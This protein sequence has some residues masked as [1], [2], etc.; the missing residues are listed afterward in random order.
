MKIRCQNQSK[1][2]TPISKKNRKL[3]VSFFSIFDNSYQN[4]I[5]LTKFVLVLVFAKVIIDW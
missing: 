1:N 5:F 4:E 3:D 2:E